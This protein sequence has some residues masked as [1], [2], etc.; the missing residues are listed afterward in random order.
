MPRSSAR[1]NDQSTEPTCW[2][3]LA[4]GG[5]C[6][7]EGL[8]KSRGIPKE[9]WANRLNGTTW[10]HQ[11]SWWG[12]CIPETSPRHQSQGLLQL[13]E[14]SRQVSVR[15]VP[16]TASLCLP[17][18]GEG[19]LSP[20]GGHSQWAL[21]GHSG[22]V[23]ITNKSAGTPS[24]VCFGGDSGGRCCELCLPVVKERF[25]FPLLLFL[26]ESW[27]RLCSG[28]GV[29]PAVLA[30][31]RQLLHTDSSLKV[32]LLPPDV[33]GWPPHLCGSCAKLGE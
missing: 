27:G 18:D 16:L 33:P 26:L 10:R 24:S 14:L 17:R 8:V 9:G 6:Y 31:S 1:V 22:R 32:T 20:Q 19:G 21:A 5:C 12:H 7:S 2:H 29:V 11:Q 15:S 28:P 3:I 13:N 30:A 4:F 23:L 25:H